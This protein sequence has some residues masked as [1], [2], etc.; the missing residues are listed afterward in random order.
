M[1]RTTARTAAIALAA[2]LVSGCGT[3]HGGSPLVM[4][5]PSPG[6]TEGQIMSVTGEGFTIC[7]IGPRKPGLYDVTVCGDVTKA[8]AVL[9]SRFPGKTV[10]V[11]YSPD[12]G[13]VHTP[14]ELVLQYWVNH[15][16]G[17]GFMVSSTRITGDGKIE[18]GIDGDLNKARTIL[19]RQFPGRTGVHAEQA[20][21][22]LRFDPKK[23]L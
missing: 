23:A 7:G 6:D 17:D 11:A 13:G 15:T 1:I 20:A 9:D 10:P 14:Q 19:D 2:V 12:D 18:V 4:P 5:T 8:H 16:K 22:E 21:H 3:G